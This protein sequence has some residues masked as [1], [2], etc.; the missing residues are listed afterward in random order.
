MH[1]YKAVAQIDA[2]SLPTSGLSNSNVVLDKFQVQGM[3]GTVGWK[4]LVF[5]ITKTS[6]PVVTNATLWDMTAGGIQVTGSPTITT[7]GNGDLSGSITYIA[8]TEQQVSGTHV[9]ELRADVASAA[10]GDSISSKINNGT[11]YSTSADYSSVVATSPNFVWTDRSLNSH[12]ES[13]FD[14]NNENFI[15][16]LPTA[17]QTVSR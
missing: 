17:L 9:Y 12:S 8:T 1:A 13:T 15:K 11:A 6:A 7:T 2:V 4:K 5:T 10:A 16:N 3:G 14:W